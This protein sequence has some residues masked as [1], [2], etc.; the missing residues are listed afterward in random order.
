MDKLD[1][2]KELERLNEWNRQLTP[3]ERRDVQEVFQKVPAPIL[4]DTAPPALE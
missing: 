1:F 4:P 2:K 3:A